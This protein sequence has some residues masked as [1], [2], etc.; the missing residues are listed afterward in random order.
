MPVKIVEHDI[1]AFLANEFR[2]IRNSFNMTVGDERKLPSDWPGQQTL[3]DLTQMAVPLFIFAATVCRFISDRRWNPQTRLRNVLDHGNQS[4]GSQLDQTY[5]PILRSQ[6][7]EV[8]KADREEIIKSFRAIVGSI[9]TLASPLSVTALSRLLDV[10]PDAVDERLDALHSVLSIPLRRTLP[11]RLL[12]LSFRDY[13][14]AEKSEFWVDE[15]LTHRSLAKHCLRLMRGA[16]HENICGLS[17]PG[18]RQ[19]TVDSAG[20]EERIP[21]ELQYACMSWV[22]HQTKVNFEVNDS[23]EIYDFLTTHFLH[24]VEALSLMGRAGKGLD[25]IRLLVDWLAVSFFHSINSGPPLT[26]VRTKQIRGCSIFWPM[27]FGSFRPIS[28]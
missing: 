6:I 19:S 11:V 14:V 25:S 3:Q 13:L 5:G 1:S 22:H 10:S 23:H 27:Q 2:K 16:L 17:L 21:P 24:W 7:T 26:V 15:G 20:L 18:M 4:H 12:H 8:P 28:P 9:V